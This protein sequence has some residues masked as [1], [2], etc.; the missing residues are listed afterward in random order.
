MDEGGRGAVRAGSAAGALA[1]SVDDAGGLDAT[2]RDA[3]SFRRPGPMVGRTTLLIGLAGFAMAAAVVLARRRSKRG[4]AACSGPSPRS[5]PRSPSQTAARR[6][7]RAAALLA[8]SALTDSALEHYRGSF[9]NKFMYAPLVASALTLAV[10]AQGGDGLPGLPVRRDVVNVAAVM[11][12]IVGTGFHIYNIAKRPGGFCWLNLFYAA[13]LGAPAALSLSGLL[14]AAGQHVRM[15]DGLVKGPLL[16]GLISAALLGTTGEA[17]LLHFRG[18]YHN[19]AMMIPVTLPPVAAMLL[20]RTAVS[21]RATVAARWWL[22]LL[23]GIGFVGAA[24]HAYGV[25]RNMGGWRNWSQNLLNG[26]P[27]PAPPA[28]TALA[29]A[30]LA[31][32]QLIEGPK[33]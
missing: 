16:A 31:S 8:A 18:A 26:P 5:E 4:K 23:T 7:D 11:T 20:A 2:Q 10:S 32:L 28:F 14:G 15:D 21:R 13:P 1:G 3:G 6:L 12:G 33:P 9:H 27:L 17:A 29:M 30:G 25:H 24:F 22:R 19:P